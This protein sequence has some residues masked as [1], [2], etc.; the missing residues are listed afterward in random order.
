MMR[1]GLRHGCPAAAADWAHRARAPRATRPGLRAATPPAAWASTRA[2]RSRLV[3]RLRGPLGGAR[4]GARCGGG[5]LGGGAG[6]SG[7]IREGRG[8]ERRSE[9]AGPVGEGRGLRGRPRAWRA[10]SS[11]PKRLRGLRR[12]RGVCEPHAP[13]RQPI[14]SPSGR[15]RSRETRKRWAGSPGGLGP[16]HERRGCGSLLQVPEPN[17]GRSKRPRPPRAAADSRKPSCKQGRGVG[18]AGRWMAGKAGEPRAPG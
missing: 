8:L 5:A 2:S 13:V 18:L 14:L 3:L 12:V 15:L 7:P 1:R 16:A 4:G 9:E 10:S 17:P 11:F 6:R